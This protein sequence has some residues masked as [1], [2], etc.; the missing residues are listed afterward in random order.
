[1]KVKELVALLQQQDQEALVL[2]A[3]SR[4]GLTGPGAEDIRE[5]NVEEAEEIVGG[6]VVV[7]KV[8]LLA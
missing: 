5:V 2:R 1:M 4:P 6:D 7:H 3:D 8:V